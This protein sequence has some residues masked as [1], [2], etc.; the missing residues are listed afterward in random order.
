MVLTSTPAVVPISAADEPVSLDVVVTDAKMRPLQDL[1]VS[2]FELTDA[3]ENRAVDAVRLQ[4][5]GGRVIGIF[6][7]EFHVHAGE[8][9]SRARARC[10]VLS[11]TA[12]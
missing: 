2:D 5:G 4:S 11:S 9:T 8:A 12:S 7:D 6:L 3:G 10:C 1:K